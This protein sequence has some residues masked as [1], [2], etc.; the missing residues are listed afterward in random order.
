MSRVLRAASMA[1]FALIWSSVLFAQVSDGNLVGTVTDASGG[2]VSGATVDLENVATGV[3]ATAKT[4]GAGQ[5]R[6]NNVP[7]GNYKLTVSAAGFGNSS[8]TNVTIELN[9]TATVNAALEVG[10]VASSVTIVE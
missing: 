7:V 9:R 8:I 4:D 3:R 6:F 1:V 2:A 10:T 5:Y